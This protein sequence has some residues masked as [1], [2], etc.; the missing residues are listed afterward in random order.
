MTRRPFS[1]LRRRLTVLMLL[2]LGLVL[3]RPFLLLAQ[4]TTTAPSSTTTEATTTEPTDASAEHAETGETTHGGGH[5]IGKELPIWTIIPFV[6]ILLSIA[7]FPLLAAHFWHHHFPKVSLFW[8]LVFAVP[9]LFV[10]K[11]LALH[12]I[13]HV[14][15]VDY[16]PFII[17]LT[18][19]YAVSGGI[20]L[21]GT[22]VGT[23]PVNTLLLLIGTVLSSV[24]G[25]TGSS[26]LLIRPVIRANAH[27]KNKAHVIVFFIFLIS[28]IGGSLTPLGDPPLFLGFLHGV[29]F[30]WTL[31]LFPE[32][33]FCTVV[34][35]VVFFLLDS[36]M[37]KRET[38]APESGQTTPLSIGG[39]FNFVFLLGIVGAVL[40]SGLAKLGS[41]PVLGIPRETESLIRDA[42]IIVIAFLAYMTTK[43]ECREENAFTWDAIKEVAYLFA[44][45]FMTIIPAIA[46]LRAGENGALRALIRM[47]N[48]EAAYFWLTGIL[49]SFLDNAPT[50]L[51]YF[52]TALGKLHL[53]EATVRAFL[54]TGTTPAG[55]EENL[56]SFEHFLKAISCGA[57]FMGANTYIG[58]APNFMVR[59]IAEENHIK[60]PSFFGFMGWSVAILIPTFIVVTF[61][62]FRG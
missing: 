41:V 22:L 25:T 53:D 4:D 17:L 32:M 56:K 48:S 46:I 18:G 3:S 13:L 51:T 59:S 36:Q 31:K 57:V 26:M 5:D 28:N 9:F 37:M 11:G 61:V 33:A 47:A 24:I 2:S 35:S 42:A 52:N 21:R 15:I 60:M 49:S 30:Q 6:G 7:L 39:S 62:F 8:S 23:P 12:E 14:Y 38:A 43:S 10:Y 50:Y 16:I 45:I 58:N 29:P 44:G 34:L 27:R 55:M 19:L 54:Y 20:V 40:F 1:M